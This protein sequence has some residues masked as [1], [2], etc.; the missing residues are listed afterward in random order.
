MYFDVAPALL[1]PA[2]KQFRYFN[3]R[4]FLR[5]HG[6]P[7]NNSAGGPMCLNFHVKRRCRLDC[8]RIA[9]HIKHS[10]AET[11][12]LNGYLT[13]PEVPAVAATAP[14]IAAA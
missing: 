14:A 5:A 13:S 6:P 4:T 1:D 2:V 11:V 10:P 8:D 3:T 9:D 12:L 7:P